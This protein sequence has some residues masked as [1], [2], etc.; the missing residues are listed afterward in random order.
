MIREATERDVPTVVEMGM[1]FLAEGPYKDQLGENY[2]QASR[3]AMQ[4]LRSN[5]GRIL[6]YEKEEQVV[7]VLAFIIFPHYFSGE[8]TAGELIWYVFPEHRN[9]KSFDTIPALELLHAAEAMAKRMGAKRFQFTAPSDE[10]AGLY[11]HLHYTKIE[12][13]FQKEL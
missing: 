9:G 3:T 8:T 2:E 1:R 12:T 13:S 7:G 5:N 6:L 11:R 10:V 4:V